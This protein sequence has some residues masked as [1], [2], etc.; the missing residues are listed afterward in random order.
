[1]SSRHPLATNRKRTGL[2]DEALQSLTSREDRREVR[3]TG[4]AVENAQAPQAEYR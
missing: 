2:K 1:M 4:Q 3:A